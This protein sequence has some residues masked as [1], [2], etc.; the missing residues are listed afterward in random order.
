MKRLTCLFLALVLIIGMG[1]L[2]DYSLLSVCRV[3]NPARTNK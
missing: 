3:L 1:I 2:C